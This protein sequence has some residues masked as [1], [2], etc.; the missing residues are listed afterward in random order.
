MMTVSMSVKGLKESKQV[1]DK[2]IAAMLGSAQIACDDALAQQTAQ[3]YAGNDPSGAT[4]KANAESTRRLKE[5]GSKRR[6]IAP[7]RPNVPLHRTGAFLSRASWKVRYSAKQKSVTVG[8][9][10]KRAR[11][12]AAGVKRLGY[13]TIAST[14]PNSSLTKGKTWLDARLKVLSR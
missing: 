8:P 13:R 7:V 14:F 5:L 2:A 6:G 9:S 1:F 12:I 3:A 10:G 11:N 4:Q